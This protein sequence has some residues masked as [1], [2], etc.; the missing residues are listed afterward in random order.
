MGSVDHLLKAVGRSGV[1]CSVGEGDV[2]SKYLVGALD[3]L[4]ISKVARY[5]DTF[6]PAVVFETDADTVALYHFDLDPEMAV[7]DASGNGLDAVWNGEPAFTDA[8]PAITT[9]E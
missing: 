4:R 8:A 9:C 2:L 5:A 3:E 6:D 7:L 1:G